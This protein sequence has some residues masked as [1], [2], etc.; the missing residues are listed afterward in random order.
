MEQEKERHLD[1]IDAADIDGEPGKETL[2]DMIRRVY[3]EN[4]NKAAKADSAGCDQPVPSHN[5]LS[6][7]L[8]V[9]ALS[10]TALLSFHL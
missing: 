8:C 3:R 10:A 6:S 4:G 1:G 5:T 2:R 9:S 7:P